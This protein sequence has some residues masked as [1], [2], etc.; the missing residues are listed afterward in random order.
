[1]YNVSEI[2]YMLK[3]DLYTNLNMIVC[4][5]V[6]NYIIIFEGRGKASAFYFVCHFFKLN[7]V[8]RNHLIN[9]FIAMKAWL[10]AY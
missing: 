7:Q 2:L 10:I 8:F 4:H 5:C 3:Y 9:S 1:M 6:T